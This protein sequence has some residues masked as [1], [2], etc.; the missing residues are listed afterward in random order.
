MS[1][2]G[3]G[4]CYGGE[5]AVAVTLGWRGRGRDDP[6]GAGCLILLRHGEESR[7][8]TEGWQHQAKTKAREGG[9]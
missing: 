6:R 2:G 8:G 3:G 4:A 5:V 9:V 1:F 7:K